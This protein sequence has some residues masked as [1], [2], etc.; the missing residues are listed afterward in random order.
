[1]D[2][3]R[4]GGAGVSVSRRSPRRG[5]PWAFAAGPLAA[6]SAFFVMMISL[7]GGY[8]RCAGHLGVLLGR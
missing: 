1:M 3:G 4:S 5:T 2:D 6:G 7:R 8:A